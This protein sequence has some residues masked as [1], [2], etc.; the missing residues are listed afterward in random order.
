[1]G[2]AG[3]RTLNDVGS[4]GA[5]IVRYVLP[6]SSDA[7][8]ALDSLAAGQRAA[9]DLSGGRLGDAAGN[10]AE[11]IASGIS[12]LPLVP[13]FVGMAKRAIPSKPAELT[14]LLSST[15]PTLKQ[16]GTGVF[17]PVFETTKDWDAAVR[18]LSQA[19]DGEVPALLT[20][21]D[22]P[23][24]IDVP[25]GRAGA[26]GHDGWGLSKMIDFHPEVVAR[27]PELLADMKAVQRSP[28]RI[29]LESKTHRAAVRLQWDGQSKTWLLTG[30]EKQ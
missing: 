2:R 9:D 10:Y 18:T 1:L 25:W 22:V 11:A 4:M 5:D 21:P 7:Q 28:N 20:H 12:A 30:F 24:P 23:N 27:F 8:S 14:K 16:M 3:E 19:K 26:G 15:G 29:Q 13:S 17:G 6:G